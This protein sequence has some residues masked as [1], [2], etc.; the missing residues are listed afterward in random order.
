MLDVSISYGCH[1]GSTCC[2]KYSY[3]GEEDQGTSKNSSMEVDEYEERE[4]VE[5]EE[6]EK[7]KK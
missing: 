4:D 5:A 1:Q 7:K 2:C 3:R 6:K